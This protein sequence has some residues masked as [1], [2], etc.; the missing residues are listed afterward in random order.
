[1]TEPNDDARTRAMPRQDRPDPDRTHRIEPRA[2]SQSRERL[3]AEAA[4]S[5]ENASAESED[6]ALAEPRIQ[7]I[8]AEATAVDPETGTRRVHT[9]DHESVSEDASASG[10]R[11]AADADATG[12]D[13]A[14]AAA[15]PWYVKVRKRIPETILGGR[16]QTSTAVLAVTW[17]LL[18]VLYGWLNPDLGSGDS[19]GTG[20]SEYAVPSGYQLTPVPVA[21]VPTT[22]EPTVTTTG[23]PET[24]TSTTD[25]GSET[26]SDTSDSSGTDGE[27]ESTTGTSGIELPGG[28]SI[29]GLTE[30]D[31]DS[32]QST[33]SP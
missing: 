28:L 33:S 23:T 8:P 11:P 5:S 32:G 12:D 20:D 10:S 29:P 9:G 4:G 27:S 15:V 16:M 13:A 25:D 26:T 2:W 18:L 7:I 6:T 21:E 19:S 24:S 3:P 17:A 22:T 1:M 30:N 14:D 31:T